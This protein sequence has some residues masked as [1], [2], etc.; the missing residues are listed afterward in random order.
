MHTCNNMKK[1]TK[2]KNEDQR[3]ES[4]QEY[5]NVEL[6]SMSTSSHQSGPE[7]PGMQSQ[8]EACQTHACHI[9]PLGKSGPTVAIL[10]EEVNSFLHHIQP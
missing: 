1:I 10:C 8:G 5:S 7:L 2:G 3:N 9:S 4:K 6:S